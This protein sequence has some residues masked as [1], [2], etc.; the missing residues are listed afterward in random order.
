M[1]LFSLYSKLPVKLQD[2]LIQLY[3]FKVEK[4][5][6]GKEYKTLLK[7]L[8]ESDKWTEKQIREYKEANLKRILEYAYN[9]TPFYKNS[10]D[11]HG[12]KPSDFTKLE[13]LEKF[14]ILT[15]EEVRENWKNMISDEFTEKDL[16]PYHTSGS[17]GKALDFYWTK[18]NLQYY[19]ATVSRGRFRF[20]ID[21]LKK[22]KHLNLTGKI[23]VPL[24]QNK[25]PYWRFRRAQNQYMLNMQHITPNKIHDIVEFIN[26]EK[27]EFFV[28]YPSILNSLATAIREAG[29]EIINPPRFFF[30]S[31]E[32]LYDFQ[33]KNIAEVFKNTQFVEHYGFSENA[34]GASQAPDGLYYE[35]FE[36][37]HLELIDTIENEDS[38]TGTLLATGF[39]NLGMPFIRY[40]VGDT[41]TFVKQKHN[42]S[43]DSNNLDEYSRIQTHRSSLGSKNKTNSDYEKYLTSSPNL[44]SQ[45]I[46]VIEGRNGDYVV[47]PEGARIMRFGYLFNDISNLMECQV[48]QYKLGEVVICM[49]LRNN[50]DD[51]SDIESSI[52]EKIKQWISPLL[53]VK[54]EYPLEIPRT[55]SGKFKAVVSFLKDK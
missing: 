49:V 1:S 53:N 29:L 10:F 36:L 55:Q 9:H 51:K 40:N 21:E 5:R 52:R 12:V 33:K 50:Q 39:Q 27:F 35:D 16:I 7:S 41:A 47:T 23:V 19:W 18:H 2:W 38:V 25:P 22:P 24:S 32:K 48:R 11:R 15:K 3:S 44:K 42:D 43:F 45:K 14:P 37:G 54:F 13:D 4:Q 46:S 26:K 20:G 34:G 28:G 31:A 30:S 8:I 6:F 17:T